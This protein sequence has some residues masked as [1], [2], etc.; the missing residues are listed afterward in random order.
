[1]LLLHLYLCDIIAKLIIII[2]TNYSLTVLNLKSKQLFQ[3][4]TSYNF[5]ERNY[6]NER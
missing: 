1:M 3:Y 2:I 6:N 5:Q 4:I